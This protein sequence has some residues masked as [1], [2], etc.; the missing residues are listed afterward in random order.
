MQ[1]SHYDVVNTWLFH[2]DAVQNCGGLIVLAT[3]KLRTYFRIIH[4]YTLFK[5]K[6]IS[7][8][9]QDKF[10]EIELCILSKDVEFR[11]RK[12]DYYY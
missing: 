3:H 9:I 1:D 2:D 7:Q 4:E 12:T 11:L 10:E 5:S 8:H 6:K